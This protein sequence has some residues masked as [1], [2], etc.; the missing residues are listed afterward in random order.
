MPRLHVV[1]ET[2][3]AGPN[4]GRRSEPSSRAIVTPR[5]MSTNPR[6][7]PSEARL[8]RRSVILAISITLFAGCGPLR[9]WDAHTTSSPTPD[10]LDPTTLTGQRVATLGV[11]APAALQGYGPALSHALVA[12][13]AEFTPPLP[14]QPIPDTLNALNQQ[15]LAAESPTCFPASPGLACSST[16]V[17]SHSTR[18]F[19][20]ATCSCLDWRDST[21]S[22]STVRDFRFEDRPGSDQHPS[23]VAPAVGHP[24]GPAALGVG[25]GSEGGER[26]PETRPYRSL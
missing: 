7:L 15:G 24:N 14:A 25:W 6:G 1:R 3:R 12:A 9:T 16:S 17:C 11:V 5:R 19:E 18:R 21:R 13:L 20:F 2:R 10:P 8:V 4:A 26:A 22:W 23:V